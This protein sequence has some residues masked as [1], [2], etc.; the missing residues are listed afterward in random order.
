MVSEG[1]RRAAAEAAECWTRKQVA[2]G[3]WARTVESRMQG[4]G[5]RPTEGR[6]R[7]AA[8][9][10]ALDTASYRVALAEFHALLGGG[11]GHL[12]TIA[13]QAPKKVDHT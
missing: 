13:E 9:R 8:K 4:K 2:S 5:R 11:N 3:T 6:V 10:A 7:A 1:V 12:L